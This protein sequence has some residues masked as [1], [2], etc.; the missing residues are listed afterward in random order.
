M[1][2]GKKFRKISIL[3]WKKERVWTLLENMFLFAV[4]PIF[5]YY[6]R[7]I[8]RPVSRGLWCLGA[9]SGCYQISGITETKGWGRK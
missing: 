8:P 4:T 7:C 9:G 1:P 6:K 3:N 2:W 5:L